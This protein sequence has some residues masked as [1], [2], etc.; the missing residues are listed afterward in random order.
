MSNFPKSFILFLILLSNCVLTSAQLPIDYIFNNRDDIFLH[1]NDSGIKPLYWNNGILYLG[2]CVKP[3]SQYGMTLTFCDTLGNINWK[4]T[5]FNPAYSVLQ[6]NDIVAFNNSGF[7]V[8]G[9]L[10]SDSLLDDQ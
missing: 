9:V 10:R 4:K 5:F 7:Y 8:G 6:G 1:K 2:F 3:N